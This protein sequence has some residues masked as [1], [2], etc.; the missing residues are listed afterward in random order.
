MLEEKIRFRNCYKWLRYVQ[1]V[2][3]L[4]QV[5]NTLKCLCHQAV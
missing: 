3:K 5:A 2:D 1:R 4:E